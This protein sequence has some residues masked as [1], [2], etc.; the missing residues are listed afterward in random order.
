LDFIT[1]EKKTKIDYSGNEFDKLH[2]DND[3]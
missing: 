1:K 3:N 2:N